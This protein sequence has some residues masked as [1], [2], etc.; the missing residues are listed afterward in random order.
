MQGGRILDSNPGTTTRATIPTLPFVFGFKIQMQITTVY[1]LT[2]YYRE[3]TQDL[4]VA[5]V[6]WNPIIRYFCYE[7]KSLKDCQKYDDA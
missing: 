1:H 3:F 2:H 4:V 5:N 6:K 7:W